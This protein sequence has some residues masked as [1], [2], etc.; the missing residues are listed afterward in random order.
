MALKQNKGWGACESG[1]VN[2][3]MKELRKFQTFYGLFFAYS[4]TYRLGKRQKIRSLWLKNS[5]Q[6]SSQI[7][8][9]T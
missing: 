9:E 8:V 7:R 4:N 5:S 2:E 3:G 6:K 1:K